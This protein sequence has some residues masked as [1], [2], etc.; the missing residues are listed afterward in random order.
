MDG[1]SNTASF[2]RVT[3]IPTVS[4]E[5]PRF[6]A[7]EDDRAFPEFPE[8]CGP[9]PG[10]L[11]QGACCACRL[12]PADDVGCHPDS[13][14]ALNVNCRDEIV[15]ILASLQ[16]LRLM[17]LLRDEILSFIAQDVNA[18]SDPFQGRP[19]F[20][21]WEILVLG[22]VRLGCNCDY[23]KLQNLAEEHRSLRR[24][25]GIGT[26]DDHDPMPWDWRRIRD[27]LCLV[28]PET[29]AKIN[30][31]GTGGPSTGADRRR[32]S[33]WRY[34]CGG[35]RHPLSHGRELAGRTVCGRFCTWGMQLASLRSQVGWRQEAYL[36]QRVSCLVWAINK[37]CR[38][39]A[40]WQGGGGVP[41]GRC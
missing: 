27:N 1:S 9:V 10:H 36:R 16:H 28:H 11:R 22:A 29:L 23:D 38:R 21:Y 33:A 12:S 3:N 8:M 14:G 2:R 4:G 20:G 19:G 26:W 39:K 31:G 7:S 32:E 15:P 24:I 25:M 18:T 40:I 37:A 30:D 6:P 13:R 5:K 41:I 35:D 34:L 17:T